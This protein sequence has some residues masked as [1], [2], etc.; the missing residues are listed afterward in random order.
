[1]ESPQDRWFFFEVLR[2]NL[3]ELVEGVPKVAQNLQIEREDELF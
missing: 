1:M 2:Q 3:F